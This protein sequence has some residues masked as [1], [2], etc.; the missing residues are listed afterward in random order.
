MNVFMMKFVLAALFILAASLAVSVAAT[1]EQYTPAKSELSGKS[2]ENNLRK[3]YEG[4]PLYGKTV[5][6]TAMAVQE[7]GK[8]IEDYVSDF[9]T[10][11]FGISA[12]DLRLTR[13]DYDEPLWKNNKEGV[14]Y[15]FY[16]Q[17]YSGLPVFSSSFGVIVNN[18]KVVLADPRIYQGINIS[19][20]PAVSEEDAIGYAIQNISIG[21]ELAESA[22]L[23]IFPV[24]KGDYKLAWRI[25]TKLA[26]GE[27][28]TVLVDAQDGSILAKFSNIV[29][30]TLSGNVTG[31]VYPEYPSQQK[32]TV[33]F[34]S[35]NVTLFNGTETSSITNANGS[36]VINAN[37]GNYTLRAT[38]QGPFV[39]VI[40]LMRQ[41]STHERNLSIPS[42]YS[43]NWDES[44]YS[45]K[46]E[47]LN[48]FYHANRIHDYFTRGSPFNITEMNYQANAT[49][50]YPGTCNAFSDGRDIFFYRAGGG[51]ES[52]A[53]SSDVIYHEYTHSVHYHV[54][55][56]TFLT[57]TGAVAEGLAD[58]FS[59][60]INNNSC[61]AEEVFGSACLR[62][63]NNT[64]RTPNN[65]TGGS[66]ADSRIFSGALWDMR[67]QLGAADN[68]TMMAMKMRPNGFSD[69]LTSLLVA[70]DDNANL[71]DK[72]PNWSSVCDSFYTK[73]G[74]VSYYCFDFNTTGSREHLFAN[75]S[76]INIPDNGGIVFSSINVSD[77]GKVKKVSAYAGITH[78]FTGDLWVNLSSPSGKA[79]ILH[80]RIGGTTDNIYTWYDNETMS[81]GTQK[82][83]SLIN[84]SAEGV[85]TLNVSDNALDD[86]GTIDEF[87]LA[88][89]IDKP[90]SITV[91]S[92][93][94]GS[95][96]PPTVLLN[97]TVDEDAA[98]C[99]RS[100]DSGDNITLNNS[101]RIWYGTASLSGGS[102]NV[103]FHCTDASNSTNSTGTIFFTSADTLS[104]S[105]TF[106]PPSDPHQRFVGRNY[107]FINASISDDVAVDSCS[108]EW[109]G[110]N[111]SMT[112]LGSGSSVTCFLNKSA[113]EG[114]YAYIVYANDSSG[115]LA[116]A[117]RTVTFDTTQPN[118]TFV[119]PDG[120]NSFVSRNYTFI[121][122]SA[123]D[124]SGVDSCV[125]EWNGI[126][127]SMTK[128]GSGSS[129]SCFINKSAAEGTH[130]Y[131]VYAND[132]IGNLAAAAGMIMFD[133]TTPSLNIAF[134]SSIF[135]PNGDGVMDE[136]SFNV[137]SSETVDF[138][139]IYITGGTGRV[140]RFN[141]VDN[142]T[143]TLKTWNGSCTP[144]YCNGTAAEGSYSIEVNVADKAGNW[145]G[146]NFTSLVL[147]I[148]P[149]QV[150][151]VNQTPFNETTT[152]RNHAVIN[153][154]TS[155]T[156][157]SIVLEWS[158][159]NET[160]NGSATAWFKR[161]PN[162]SDGNYTFRIHVNDSAG[163]RNV[164]E[165]RW[166]YVNVTRNASSVFNTINQSL[167]ARN[168]TFYVM[169]STG[170]AVDSSILLS[171]ENYTL[172][173]NAS[174]IMVETIGFSGSS[175]NLSAA[176]NMTSRIAA[177]LNVSRAVNQSGG[178]LDSYVWV[179]L[180]GMLPAGSFTAKITFP[181]IY[182]L[183]FYLNGT[184]DAPNV[185]RITNICNSNAS[186]TP[187]Y[188]TSSDNT[189]ALYLPSFS[190][191]AGGN[192][193]Q[194]PS[195]DVSS[196]SVA[197]YSSASINLSY[198][199]SDNIAVSQCWYSLNNSTNITLANCTNTTITAAEGSNTLIVY[200]ND[201]ANNTNYTAV[202]F[203]L[204]T[205]I[206]STPSPSSSGGSAIFPTPTPTATATPTPLPQVC[207]SRAGHRCVAGACPSECAG[208]SVLYSCADGLTC[209]RGCPYQKEMKGMT[210]ANESPEEIKISE[211]NITEALGEETA[212]PTGFVFLSPANILSSLIATA[213]ILLAAL[214]WKGFRNKTMTS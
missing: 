167:A 5:S 63:L 15:V 151:F 89:F 34:S 149:I 77:K 87:R 118:I 4:M 176:I 156:P 117:L 175:I 2:M 98:S 153:V 198:I 115:N 64:L 82:L 40:D 181:R 157:N 205:S 126:N 165:T 148:T 142:A 213:V 177:E 49:V 168:I 182:A 199:A 6:Q 56:N 146:T 143:S 191:G 204:D 133:V 51:C 95:A 155:E 184:R 128:I 174:S 8:Q 124:A 141:A 211:E 44:N 160:M 3:V 193:T 48:L 207:D 209:C 183:Y 52:T 105:I 106:V 103:K 9:I 158:G 162:L 186:N 110:I 79:V 31:S 18:R 7:S 136:V 122:V 65:L 29:S 24:N 36:Y 169:N 129:V 112:K 188:N 125:L 78:T 1:Q 164:S 137:T 12:A 127:Q 147:D 27:K 86:I 195:I 138:D 20:N 113:A 69:Y 97:I 185:T 111:Q 54:Y 43:W 81:N 55:G 84:E 192:D 178:T 166:I 102:H 180:N 70:D 200:A 210:E 83:A 194:A 179:D 14:Y 60:A 38:L 80:Q 13:T 94:N 26:A 99:S 119:S 59:A 187:C 28:W 163:N 93:A 11:S 189:S 114:T 10:N 190:G 19:V 57:P 17:V 74:I 120:N 33:N 144:Q 42:S 100:I 23:V 208:V 202:A 46:G 172:R 32:I 145:N 66:H 39:K 134:T 68:L 131:R 107:T 22:T 152:S 25:E 76:D 67:L 130:N 108:L 73:H 91:V 45:Y 21:R 104:P 75:L 72:T 92:P 109:S 132:S 214:V 71:S 53:L 171:Y 197:T 101:G 139:T 140:K 206:P 121:N 90:P 159:I 196:P 201:T 116:I 61:M 30:E 123:V 212:P 173:F 58:Y 35:Q 135:S 150:N 16:E 88:I 37:S 170:H 154:T 62:N 41:N 50:Q 85:W 96:Q 47:A 203:T 161:K